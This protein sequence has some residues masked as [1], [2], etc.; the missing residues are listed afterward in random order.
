LKNKIRKKKKYWFVQGLGQLSFKLHFRHIYGPKEWRL[1]D[2]PRSLGFHITPPHGLRLLAAV[3]TYAQLVKGEMSQGR[4][5]ESD[6]CFTRAGQGGNF[7][8]GF[9]YGRQEQDRFVQ[10]FAGNLVVG[11]I[12]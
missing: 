1:A 7:G 4:R 5:A 2:A 10:G 6:K 8:R 12:N 3:G 11:D 9:Q